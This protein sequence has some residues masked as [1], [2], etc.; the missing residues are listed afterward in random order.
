[1]FIVIVFCVILNTDTMTLSSNGLLRLKRDT[2]HKEIQSCN[3]TVVA[4]EVLQKCIMYL[5]SYMLNRDMTSLSSNINI[6]AVALH[7]MYT[8]Y[9][10]Y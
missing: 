9:L 4:Y 8:I 3:I 5:S 2:K 7:M 1:M 6:K 10:F